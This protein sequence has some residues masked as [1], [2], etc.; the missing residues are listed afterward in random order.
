M[1]IGVATM[2]KLIMGIAML[3]VAT[4]AGAFGPS[5]R[6]AKA[7][8]EYQ[9]VGEAKSCITI[10]Q[11]R[12][13]HVIDNQTIDF[14]MAG[15]KVYRNRLSQS[16]PGL[17]FEERFSYRTSQSQLCSVDIIRVLQS[18]GGRLEEGVGCGLGKFQPVEKVP[19][20]KNISY[21][22]GEF[23][24]FEVVEPGSTTG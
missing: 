11:I 9:P 14:K 17:G 2:K 18:Y 7:L 6:R 4:T 20:A 5:E 15:G 23:A 16:C 12:S 22:A 1:N 19:T 8:A 10:N 13:T 24:P 3:A 21:D